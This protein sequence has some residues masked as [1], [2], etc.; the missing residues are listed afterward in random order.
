MV[1]FACILFSFLL[2]TTANADDLKNHNAVDPPKASKATLRTQGTAESHVIQVMYH[3]LQA[4]LHRYNVRMFLAWVVAALT[5]V[6]IGAVFMRCKFNGPVKEDNEYQ[7]LPSNAAI[8]ATRPVAICE[9][10]SARDPAV[11]DHDIE[12]AAASRE[13][14]TPKQSRAGALAVRASAAAEEEYQR[15]LAEARHRR[16]EE[17]AKKRAREEEQMLRYSQDQ[18]FQQSLLMD[19]LKVLTERRDTLRKELEAL[20]AKVQVAKNIQRHAAQR[21]AQFGGNGP[22]NPQL[23]QDSE[24]ATEQLAAAAERR[25]DLVAELEE[26]EMEVAQKNELLAVLLI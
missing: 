18:E 22:L 5:A 14:K 19:Q 23:A 13:H 15:R 11:V 3:V 10:V 9:N 2:T 17:A 8:V 24:R 6:I 12:R 25:P 7:Q 26:V 20:D 4:R 1:C 21:L 16:A